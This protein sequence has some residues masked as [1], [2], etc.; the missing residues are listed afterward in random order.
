MTVGA[1]IQCGGL[2]TMGGLGTRSNPTRAVKSGIVAMVSIFQVGFC[3]GWAPLSHVVAAEIP[4]QRLRDMTYALGSVFN[5]AIQFAVS[6]S[7]PYL[8][9]EPYAGLGSKVGF[10]FGTTAAMAI[11]F[12]VFFIPECGGKSLEE[13]DEL[14]LEGVPIS[15]FGK[16]ASRHHI[17]AFE[18]DHEKTVPRVKSVEV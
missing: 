12:T 9:N 18:E 17:E 4:T 15:K 7:I 1:V 14:F 3:L 11:V 5:I 16:T 13:I 2:F 10:I 8:L 6:F